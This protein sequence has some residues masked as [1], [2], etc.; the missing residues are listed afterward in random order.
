MNDLDKDTKY[1]IYGNKLPEY[2]DD[3]YL[4]PYKSL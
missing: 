2:Y 3:R 1:S 4:K